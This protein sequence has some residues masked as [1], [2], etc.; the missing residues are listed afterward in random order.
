MPHSSIS[1]LCLHPTVRALRYVFLEKAETKNICWP[2]TDVE[3]LRVMQGFRTA[4]GVPGCLGVIDGS[5][6]P[7]RKPTKAQANQDADSYYGYK[8][9]IASL[10][11]AVCDADLQFTYV[12]AGA[13][14]CVGDAGLFSRCRLMGYLDEGLMRTLN[15]PL[16]FD[17]GTIVNIWPYLVGDS[18]FPLGH[19]LMKAIEPPPSTGVSTGQAQQ[20]IVRRTS[21]Y[22]AGFW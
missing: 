20:E 17:D 9:G 18:A 8:G 4:Y 2:K 12:S 13:P 1:E 15:V 11:L 3:Q 6:I 5:L 7:Q 10:L 16:Y 19:H 14:A 22:R 21:A